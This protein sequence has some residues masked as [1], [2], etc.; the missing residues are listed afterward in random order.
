MITYDQC[1]SCLSERPT[2]LS[3]VGEPIIGGLDLQTRYQFA[4]CRDCGAIWT[5]SSNEGLGGHD[6][7]WY[8][9][10]FAPD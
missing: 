3:I 7:P 4:Q 1:K 8:H 2:T 9:M 5:I 10:L 6:G